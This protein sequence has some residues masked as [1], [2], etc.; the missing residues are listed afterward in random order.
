M[1]VIPNN[2]TWYFTV[3]QTWLFLSTWGFQFSVCLCTSFCFCFDAADDDTR[4]PS[5]ASPFFVLWHSHTLLCM[6]VYHHGT[7][8][9]IQSWTLYDLDLWHQYQNYIFTMNF[10]IW[11]DVFALWHRHTKFLH[12]GVLPWDMCTFST[13]VWLWPLTYMWVAGVILKHSVSWNTCENNCTCK[14]CKCCISCQTKCTCPC[15]LKS[16]DEILLS[17]L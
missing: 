8:C 6:W 9:H 15:R 14:F 2:V 1:Y 11:Q 10:W 5:F 13:L 7:M 3:A 12:M 4:M 17:Y 16:L